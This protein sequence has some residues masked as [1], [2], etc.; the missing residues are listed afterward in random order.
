MK[1]LQIRFNDEGEFLEN[2]RKEDLDRQVTKF[3]EEEE[4]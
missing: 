1:K 3:L 2:L 4:E